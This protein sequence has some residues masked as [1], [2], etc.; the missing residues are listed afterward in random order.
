M[1]RAATGGSNIV[2]PVGKAFASGIYW[3]VTGGLA[4]NDA[5]ALTAN[6]IAIN[7]DFK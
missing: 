2:F 3:C 1:R 7:V 4:D 5:T 6:T